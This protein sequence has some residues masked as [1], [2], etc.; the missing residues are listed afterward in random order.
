MFLSPYRLFALSS[1]SAFVVLLAACNGGSSSGSDEGADWIGDGDQI[2]VNLGSS[3][4]SSIIGMNPPD[5][6]PG[7]LPILEY[8]LSI[9]FEGKDRAVLSVNN[10]RYPA[11]LFDVVQGDMSRYLAFRLVTDDGSIELTFKDG[12]ISSS[13]PDMAT[14]KYVFLIAP[15]KWEATELSTGT[16]T[17]RKR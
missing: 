12:E 4:S 17:L 14:A 3:G 11:Q 10:S 5:L 16:A 15:P 7:S 1:A 9:L 13:D 8:D 6:D 2:D